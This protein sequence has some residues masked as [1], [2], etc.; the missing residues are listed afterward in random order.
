M[1]RKYYIR[2]LGVGI[3]VT[4][5]LFIVAMVFK[6][7]TLSDAEIRRQARLL[8]MVDAQEAA[9]TEEEQDKQ[10]EQ[11]DQGKESE[12][13]QEADASDK[14]SESEDT[15]EGEAG[16]DQTSS[17]DRPK[18]Q[19][20]TETTEDEEGN[21]T[22]VET[23]TGNDVEEAPDER[24]ETPGTEEAPRPQEPDTSSAENISISVKSGQNSR[25]VANA[26][27][28]AGLVDSASDFDH[29][30][31]QNGYDRIIRPG[32]FEIPEGSSYEQIAAILIGRN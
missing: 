9:D 22:T 18:D 8:G 19:T 7:P 30:L 13:G 1:K 15:E 28:S 2:G 25:N 23:R 14:T 11:D 31:E 27:Q 20:T 3:I 5:L 10:E 29:F 32:T 12:E 4:A 24:E 6:K 17:D 16:N 21:K 26:L